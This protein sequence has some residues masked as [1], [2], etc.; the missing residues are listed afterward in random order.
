MLEGLFGILAFFGTILGLVIGAIVIAVAL[1]THHPQQARKGGIILEVWIG[2]YAAALLAASFTSQPKYLER[3]MERC[4][5]EMCYSVKTLAVTQ[6]IGAATNQFKAQ[7]NYYVVTVQLRSDSRRTAQK[8]SQPD[9][10]IVDAQGKRYSQMVNAG[11]E[12]GFPMGQPVTAAQL[13]E[14]KIQPGETVSR[15]VAFD[16]PGTIQQPGLVVNEGIGP[17]SAIIIGDEN[18]VFHAKT[19]FLLNP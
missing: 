12:P 18:S 1:L 13:W 6:T 16:L 3:G 9:L 19:E 14:Q 11:A 10:F 15:T 2:L 4:F 17:L 5:D 7:G 8:P